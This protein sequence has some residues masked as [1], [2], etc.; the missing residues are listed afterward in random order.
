VNERKEKLDALCLR[1]HGEPHSNADG[2]IAGQDRRL[3]AED[4]AD[5]CAGGQLVDRCESCHMGIREPVT[6]T[7]ASMALKGKK[8]A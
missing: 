4:S 8:P 2:R 5:Q 7:A 6:L 1:A 3:D